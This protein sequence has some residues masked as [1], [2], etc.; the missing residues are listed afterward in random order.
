MYNTYTLLPT[1]PTPGCGRS[2]PPY[3]RLCHAPTCMANSCVLALCVSLSCG[4]SLSLAARPFP[5]ARPSSCLSAFVSALAV[6]S[7]RLLV[8]RILA[9]SRVDGLS[10]PGTARGVVWMPGNFFFEYLS[11]RRHHPLLSSNS[12]LFS[13]LPSPHARVEQFRPPTMLG[14]WSGSWSPYFLRRAAC[15]FFSLTY[16]GRI[17]ALAQN[18]RA[19]IPPRNRPNPCKQ[20]VS[21]A[22]W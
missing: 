4:V 19:Q 9:T 12:P 10:R 7:N 16:R 20:A 13:L 2:S 21:H 14:N 5:A 11:D 1:P 3:G 18:H 22:G 17:P 8:L 6:S 15:F